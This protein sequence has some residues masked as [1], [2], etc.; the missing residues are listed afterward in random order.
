MGKLTTGAP[1][2]TDPLAG[3]PPPPQAGVGCPAGIVGVGPTLDPGCY[4]NISGVS[5]LNPGIY[6]VT[7][8]FNA[9]DVTGVGV[10]IYLTGMGKIRMGN[11]TQLTLS[12][13]TSGPYEGIAIFQDPSDTQNFDADNHVTI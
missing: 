1:M 11:N 4:T 13:P 8:T 9:G 3:L 10:M 6:Y 7:G 12:A 2:P 5:L